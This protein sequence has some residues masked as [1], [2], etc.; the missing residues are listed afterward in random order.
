MSPLL[1][2]SPLKGTKAPTF[3]LQD[4]Q[5]N[6]IS[7]AD[8]RGKRIAL[9]F[10][11]SIKTPRCKCQVRNVARNFTKL[12]KENIVVFGISY[13]S[14]KTNEKF[15]KKN[16]IGFPLLFDVD[17]TVT[18]AYGVD[19]WCFPSRKTFLIDEKGIIVEIIGD[20]N[21]DDHTTQITNG[22]SFSKSHKA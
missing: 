9:I 20:V 8:F 15:S 3:T 2:E 14:Q 10:Y 17:K 18:K 16:N 4:K 6:Y 11:P 7:L 1:C 22:F 21:V 5:G 19:S 12:K 13:S